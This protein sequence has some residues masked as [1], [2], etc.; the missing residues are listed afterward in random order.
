MYG[1][2][3]KKVKM[4]QIFNDNGHVVQLHLSKLVLVL[5][6]K[7]K[8]RKIMAIMQFNLLM[9]K[10]QKTILISLQKDTYQNLDQNLLKFQLNSNQLK[11]LNINQANN[12]MLQFLMLGKLLMLEQNQK[13]RVLQELLKD[14]ILLDKMQPMVINTLKELL[15]PLDKHHGHQGFLRE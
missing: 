15:D 1:L 9:A 6:L 12:L 4:T 10:S 7:S 3:G 13:V 11:I 5:F 8:K 14:T 2:I